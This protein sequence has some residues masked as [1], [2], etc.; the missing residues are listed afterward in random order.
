MLPRADLG[1]PTILALDLPASET[2]GTVE[3][4]A[5]TRG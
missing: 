3:G 2:V 4:S 5:Y 1:L